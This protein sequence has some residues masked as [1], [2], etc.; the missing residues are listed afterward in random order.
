MDLPLYLKHLFYRLV[1]AGLQPLPSVEELE[2]SISVMLVNS[3]ISV[4]P[5]RPSMPGL[6]NIGGAG[7]RPPK[8]LPVDIQVN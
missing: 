8:A 2:K 7:I 6:I 1:L 4:S 3:H 5:P